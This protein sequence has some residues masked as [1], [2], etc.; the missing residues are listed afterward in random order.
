MSLSDLQ[1]EGF[2]DLKD[3]GLIED[4]HA[5][6]PILLLDSATNNRVDQNLN[7]Q[8]VSKFLY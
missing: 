4:I 2:L 6:G 8:R 1:I 5:P 3:V 7:C